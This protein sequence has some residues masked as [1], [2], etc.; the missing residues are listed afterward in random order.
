MSETQ[1]DPET[2]ELDLPDDAWDAEDPPLTE[3]LRRGGRS[4]WLAPLPLGLMA[5]LLLGVGFVAGVQVQ[6][7]QG[8]DGA[9]AGFARG[10]SG[11]PPGMA[12]MAG[13]QRGGGGAGDVATG[14]ATAG[15]AGSGAGTT[16]GEVANVKGSRLYVTTSDGATVEVRVGAQADVQR[17]SHSSARGVHP[18]DSVIVQGTSRSDGSVSATAVQATAPGLSALSLFGGGPGG[19]GRAGAGREGAAPPGA[20]STGRSGSD[21]DQLFDGG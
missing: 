12:A 13:G 1:L 20:G 4:A 5:V 8:D 14:G 17:L 16:V 19:D 9:A 6:K 18:G 7:G 10:G 11:G 21:V 15:A 3:D 2:T